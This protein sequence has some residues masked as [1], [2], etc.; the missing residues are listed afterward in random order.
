VTGQSMVL[1]Q[2]PKSVTEANNVLSNH[3]FENCE[4]NTRSC[5]NN[6]NNVKESDKE[7]KTQ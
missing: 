4:I 6:E 1:N 3:K 5:Q 2:Y 7:A